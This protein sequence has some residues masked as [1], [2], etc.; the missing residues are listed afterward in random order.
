MLSRAYKILLRL[1]PADYRALFA[2]EKSQVFETAYE[3]YRY[4]AWPEIVRFAIGEAIGLLMGAGAEWAAKLTT[5]RSHRGR[6][7]PDLRM[8]R[9]PGVSKELW[10]SG[11]PMSA[12]QSAV[13]DDLAGEV[14]AAQRRIALLVSRTVHAIANHDF[15]G[16]R[17]YYREEREARENLQRLREK[18]NIDE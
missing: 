8:M 17:S 16:A 2:E 7:L 4:R 14:M 5:D 12:G 10:F 1:Y 13:A 9:P 6:Y 18:H 11:A 3:E 15:Q